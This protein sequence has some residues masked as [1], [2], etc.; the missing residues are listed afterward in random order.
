MWWTETN[1]EIVV[2]ILLL[3]HYCCLLLY[4]LS[5]RYLKRSP[6]FAFGHHIFQNVHC[7]VFIWDSCMSGYKNV[8]NVTC[9]LHLIREVGM[10]VYVSFFHTVG[11]LHKGWIKWFFACLNKIITFTLTPVNQTKMKMH[12]RYKK[13]NQTSV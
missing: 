10:Y 2:V 3:R 8:L 9:W 1:A 6:L 7:N 4:L 11:A 13:W 12:F 5:F